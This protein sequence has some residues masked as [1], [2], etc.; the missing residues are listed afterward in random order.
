MAIRRGLT[1]EEIGPTILAERA[2]RLYRP[3]NVTTQGNPIFD[4]EYRG[5]T[6]RQALEDDSHWNAKIG[7]G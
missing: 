3:G 1:T 2:L 7:K 6:Y 4:F 5:K